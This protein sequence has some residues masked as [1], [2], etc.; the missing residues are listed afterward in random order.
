MTF[1]E[2]AHSETRTHGLSNPEGTRRK[3]LK[4]TPILDRAETL[5]FGSFLLGKMIPKD[6]FT[7]FRMTF[8]EK[9]H[10][11]TRTHGLTLTKGTLYP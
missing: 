4:K 5:I 7:A 6:H 11:E 3:D 2:K 8:I 9:A 1:V 10:S